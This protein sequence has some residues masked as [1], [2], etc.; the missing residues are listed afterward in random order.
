V[1]LVALALPQSRAAEEWLGERGNLV[2]EWAAIAVGLAGLALRCATVLFAPDGSSSRDTHRL[3]ATGLNTTGTY[4]IVRHPLYLGAGMLWFGAVLST[5]VWWLT[6]VVALLYWVYIERIMLGEEEYLASTFGDEF[7]AWAAATPTFIP[8][9]SGWRRPMGS[10]QWKRVLS[11]HN[12][13]LALASSVTLFEFL[14]DDLHGGLTWTVWYHDHPDLVWFLAFSVIVSIAAIA[15][16]RWPTNQS[17]VA[18]HAA[19]SP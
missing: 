7:S 15:I 19:T 18:H 17:R 8:R 14:E 5:R 10:L 11:E 16:R 9:W 4:S 2:F 1:P 6:A 3:R 13:L 12:A